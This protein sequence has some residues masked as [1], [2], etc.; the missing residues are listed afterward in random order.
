MLGC[1]TNKLIFFVFYLLVTFSVFPLLAW[2]TPSTLRIVD[3][4]QPAAVILIPEDS[5][6]N[7]EES[8]GQLQSHIK[9]STGATLPVKRPSMKHSEP[10]KIWLGQHLYSQ[11]SGVNLDGLDDHGFVISFPEEG[12]MVLVGPTDWG[13][14]FGV[15]E[16]LER[17]LGIRW[18]LPGP[19]GEHI[20][21]RSTLDIPV[22]EIREEPVFISRSFSGLRLRAQS[23]WAHRNR[24]V[25][26]IKF[27]HNLYKL[28][29]PS[30]YR[31]THPEFYPIIDGKRY[32][33]ADNQK[34]D[35]QPCFSAPGLVE[36]AIKNICEFFSR[37]PDQ[38]SYSLGV[39]DRRGYCEC[40]R[41]STGQ[42][43]YLGRPHLSDPYFK[44]ANAVVEGVLKQYPDKRFGCLA[45]NS[46]ADPPSEVQVHPHIIPYMTYDRMKWIDK[47]I[48][49][50]G[51][52]LTERWAKKATNLGWYDY[53]Y[54]TPYLVPRVYFRKMAEYYRY[55][56]EN[57]IRAMYA[58]AYPNWGEGPKLFLAAKLQWNPS[59]DMNALLEDWYV[60]AVGSKAAPSLRAYYEHWEHFWTVRVLNS[61]WF[62]KRGQY[63][64]FNDPSYLNMLDYDDISKSR[65][66]LETVVKDAETDK[67]K[68]RAG[69]LLRAFEY[70]EASAISYL[71]LVANRRLPGKSRRYYYDVNNRRYEL[72]DEFKKDPVLI[73]PRHFDDK[74]WRKLHFAPK[75][76]QE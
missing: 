15:Y 52:E 67:Q 23:R 7:L 30:R 76:P 29:P 70:Y 38:K 2:G 46:I 66:L 59:L 19:D 28:F 17:F 58:E 34:S 39:N 65:E 69:L 5:S 40:E 35:W 50:H 54:G 25:G 74:R 36:E 63:L 21:A 12:N 1:R 26:K 10:V 24:M 43:N 11:R 41:C 61:K 42:T 62:T 9:K 53:I 22:Q 18:L 60:L 27:H 68:A 3:N 13:T 64:K 45:Y 33:P 8:A 6:D 71:G 16:F 48:E 20:P 4:G 72:T 56:Y 32:L 14:K 49:Q 57:G 37:Y 55:G 73:H 47:E 44:W 51:K 31:D 75:M